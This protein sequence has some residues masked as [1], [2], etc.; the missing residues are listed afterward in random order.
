MF[1]TLELE[2]EL[3]VCTRTS[4]VRLHHSSS[5]LLPGAAFS[6]CSVDLGGS[7][8]ILLLLLLTLLYYYY[9]YYYYW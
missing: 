2:L 5:T 1:G 4:G 3:V 9:Y 6:G 8:R 7:S